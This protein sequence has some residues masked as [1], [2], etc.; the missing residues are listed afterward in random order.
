MRLAVILGVERA[1]LFTVPAP[2][3]PTGHNN[4]L[5]WHADQDGAIMRVFILFFLA[6]T[7]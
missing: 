4:N 5:R 7:A 1:T 2:N 6:A 3:S